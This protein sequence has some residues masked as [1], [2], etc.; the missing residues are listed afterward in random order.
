MEEKYALLRRA[1]WDVEG[2]RRRLM[3]DDALYQEL[4]MKYKKDMHLETLRMRLRDGDYEGAFL[5]A[6]TLKGIAANLGF[7]PMKASAVALTEL[8]RNVKEED[9][10]RADVQEKMSSL[11]KA[12][13]DVVALLEK[14]G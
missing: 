8:L 2:T 10:W 3:N 14:L 1:G 13:E 11:E 12:H 9:A 7:V 4:L 5:E 6:H